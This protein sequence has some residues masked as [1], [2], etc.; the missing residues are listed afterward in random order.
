VVDLQVWLERRRDRVEKRG[1]PAVKIHCLSLFFVWRKHGGVNLRF[2]LARYIT[3]GLE[4]FLVFVNHL[5]I[6]VS[7]SE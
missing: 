7:C 6:K 5:S 4:D 3:L 2:F 1:G